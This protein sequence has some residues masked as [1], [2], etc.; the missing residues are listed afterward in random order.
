M[1]LTSVFRSK[2]STVST[3]VPEFEDG[4][5]YVYRFI[6][7]FI[8]SSRSMDR[9][10]MT[11]MV[12]ESDLFDKYESNEIIVDTIVSLLCVIWEIIEDSEEIGIPV[13]MSLAYDN[14][15]ANPGIE[16]PGSL[17]LRISRLFMSKYFQIRDYL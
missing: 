7:E 9:E 1:D 3:G 17:H 8:D 5:A 6:S 4:M 2:N 13:T 10:W 16:S 15:L 14:M 12:R 11:F